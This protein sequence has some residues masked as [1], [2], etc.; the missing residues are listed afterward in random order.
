MAFPVLL[1]DGESFT[2]HTLFGAS[3]LSRQREQDVAATVLSS[4]QWKRTQFLLNEPG[5]PG[6][7]KAR[8][9]P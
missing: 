4:P 2:T 9:S 6:A 1:L 7:L 8:L 3:K 5:K